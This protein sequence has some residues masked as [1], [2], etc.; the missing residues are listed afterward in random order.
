MSWNSNERFLYNEFSHSGACVV[1]QKKISILRLS[2]VHSLIPPESRCDGVAILGTAGVKTSMDD[3]LFEYKK[4]DPVEEQRTDNG[5][6]IKDKSFAIAVTVFAV[7]AVG[8]LFRTDRVD[9]T[10]RAAAQSMHQSQQCFRLVSSPC[11]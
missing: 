7:A 2:N 4:H 11:F 6:I 1:V 10:M 8:V 5:F 3:E 9:R